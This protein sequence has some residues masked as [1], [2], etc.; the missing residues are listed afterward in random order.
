MLSFTIWKS[1]FGVYLKFAW[2][3]LSKN[4]LFRIFSRKILTTRCHFRTFWMPWRHVRR[5]GGFSLGKKQQNVT[6]SSYVD[7]VNSRRDAWYPKKRFPYCD[8]LSGGKKL[9]GFQPGHK[10]DK[11][12]V[13]SA[14]NGQKV[15]KKLVEM[16]AKRFLWRQ[17]R[18]KFYHDFW[19]HIFVQN[20]RFHNQAGT[21]TRR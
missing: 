4:S 14:R 16:T 9:S 7:Q 18:K 21:L 17:T 8:F 20:S 2:L 11:T 12:R 15:R 3:K 19:I 13:K 10:I 5:F 1:F 6:F